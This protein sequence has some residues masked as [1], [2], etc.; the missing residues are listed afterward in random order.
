MGAKR[1]EL[2]C[3]YCDS[4]QTFRKARIDHF[5]HLTISVVSL[6]VWFPVWVVLIM[7]REFQP[8]VCRACRR[9]Y[10]RLPAA[11]YLEN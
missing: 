11:R 6:G 9:K 2:H 7:H 3:C 5:F 8:W 10:R 1:T 4:T